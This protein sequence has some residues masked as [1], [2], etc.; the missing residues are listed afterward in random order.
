MSEKKICEIDKIIIVTTILYEDEKTESNS[1]GA[2]CRYIHIAS[3]NESGF[4]P[5]PVL[6]GIPSVLVCLGQPPFAPLVLA[7]Y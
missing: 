6:D 5:K 1:S 7:Y 2:D 3:V 4:P